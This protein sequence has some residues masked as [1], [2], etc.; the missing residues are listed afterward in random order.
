M[1][2]LPSDHALRV[3]PTESADFPPCDCCGDATR[4]V[5][6]YVHA[7]DRTVAA[8]FVQWT[9]GGVPAH[10]ALFDLVLGRWGDGASP[11][12]R[13]LVTLDYRL[14]DTGPG[15]MVIDSGGRP[16]A[17]PA[18]VGR[19]LTRTEVVGQSIVDEAFPVADA[20]LAQDARI[21]ELL[22]RR[23]VE[24][25]QRRPWWQFWAAR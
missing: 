14:T 3:E 17:D 22:G 21:A 20:V 8:Y 9:V 7:A 18:I 25:A 11:T 16:A 12:D 1:A 19:A 10:G 5:W 4:R 6:G 13:V 2:S 23:G 15:F 24:P